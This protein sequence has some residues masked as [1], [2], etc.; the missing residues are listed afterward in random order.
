MSNKLL[1]KTKALL[2]FRYK[3]L[4]E[5]TLSLFHSLCLRCKVLILG[6]YCLYLNVLLCTHI[7]RFLFDFY[8]FD[9][10]VCWNSEPY[11]RNL[12]YL[13]F[14]FEIFSKISF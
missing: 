10:K 4:S 6:N 12:L 2:V 11:V 8:N 5:L 7:V 1:D 3:E 9:A 14:I 13:L